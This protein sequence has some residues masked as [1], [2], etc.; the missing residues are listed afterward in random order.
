MF[1]RLNVIKHLIPK[2]KLDANYQDQFLSTP[3]IIATEYN[4]P[5]VLSYLLQQGADSSIK[6][7]K[8]KTVMDYAN[9]KGSQEII[10]ILNNHFLTSSTAKTKRKL[11]DD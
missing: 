11:S 2:W 1:G 8:G 5:T 9:D 3:L 10:D 6:D 7:K 4:H